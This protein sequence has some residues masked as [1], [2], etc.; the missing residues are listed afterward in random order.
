L[1]STEIP[2]T[3]QYDIYYDINNNIRIVSEEASSIPGLFSGFTQDNYFETCSG[4]FAGCFVNNID[5]YNE[6]VFRLVEDKE[7]ELFSGS[8]SIE[9][10]EIDSPRNR[11]IIH[12]EPGSIRTELFTFILDA[13]WVGVKRVSGVP[14]LTCNDVGEIED[15]SA[16]VNFNVKNVGESSG[17]FELSGSC[18]VG[19]VSFGTDRLTLNGGQSRSMSAIVSG[20]VDQD[21][22]F[23]CT[24]KAIDTNSRK[25]DSCDITGTFVEFGG[26]N[27]RDTICVGKSLGTCVNNE[28]KFAECPETCGFVGGQSQ[29]LSKSTIDQPKDGGFLAGVNR[30]FV[31]IGI[32]A[33]L[34][35][36]AIVVFLVRRFL[37]GRGKRK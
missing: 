1:G 16:R 28:I 2:V 31:T 24:I 19:G 26:C 20:V 29:C 15:G 21:T 6:D 7:L 17:S 33:T 34:L 9:R 27:E 22:D 25:S 8:P 36:I 4:F 30:F 13:E 11:V 5:K 12:D 3:P 32:I 23:I 37:K 35:V 14:E 18:N 10:I